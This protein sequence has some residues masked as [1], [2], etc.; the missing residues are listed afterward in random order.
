MVVRARQSFEFFRGVTWFLGSKR[1]LSKFKYRI[2][3][4]LISIIKLQ[5]S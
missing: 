2:L 4:R 3:H 1:A 5:N